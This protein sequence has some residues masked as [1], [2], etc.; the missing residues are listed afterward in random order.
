VFS[1]YEIETTPC[2]VFTEHQLAVQAIP[3]KIVSWECTVVG[4]ISMDIARDVNGNLW[5]IMDCQKNLYYIPPYYQAE[6]E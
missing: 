1:K 6:G 5:T 2:G 3:L 4:H